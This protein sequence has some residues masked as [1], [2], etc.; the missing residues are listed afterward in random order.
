MKKAKK[1]TLRA[2]AILT[3][4]MAGSKA[5]VAA[6]VCLVGALMSATSAVHAG[7]GLRGQSQA[8]STDVP[9]LIKVSTFHANSLFEVDPAFE[10]TAQKASEQ[11]ADCRF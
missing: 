2:G 5:Q 9:I 1:L 3:K 6:L 11:S 8:G 10:Q 4:K 7:E